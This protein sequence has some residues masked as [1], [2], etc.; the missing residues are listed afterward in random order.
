MRRLLPILAAAGLLARPGQC[1]PHP[2]EVRTDPR[3]ELL[4]AVHHLAASRDSLARPSGLILDDS[5][6]GGNLRRFAAPYL[7][8]PAVDSYLEALSS[9]L[10][11]VSLS[12]LVLVAVTEPDF[13]LSGKSPF[14]SEAPFQKS[15][16]AFLSSFARLAEESSFLRFFHSQS[17]LL[18]SYEENL[19]REARQADHAAT[20]ED[21]S[22]LPV[23]IRHILFVS[24][25]LTHP[26]GHIGSWGEQ[27]VSFNCLAPVAVKDGSPFFDF[28]NRGR[29]VLQEL[30]HSLMDPLAETHRQEILEAAIVKEQRDTAPDC[31]QPVNC[32]QQA[33]AAGLAD[34]V[35]EWELERQGRPQEAYRYRAQRDKLTRLIGL[36]LR[37][38]ERDR[39]RYPD[40][41][42][43]YPDLLKA[44][45]APE[46][47]GPRLPVSRTDDR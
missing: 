9:G 36:Q 23:R 39:S 21:Y 7:R 40:L 46:H 45:G 10:D 25:F 20:L 35:W 41:A 27:R 37:R 34:R 8:H 18:L 26:F 17:P 42:A 32:L 22:A 38:F 5:P 3:L 19:R 11:A 2:P 43:F 31:V 24:P 33:V 1:R 30:G 14:P 28:A 16:A 4:A 6:Y 47:A 15:A 29:L 13:G 44:L 12:L